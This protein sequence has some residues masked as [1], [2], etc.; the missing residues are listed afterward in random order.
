MLIVVSFFGGL[1]SHAFLGS[2]AWGGLFL[3]AMGVY[4]YGRYKFEKERPL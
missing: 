2:W 4:T 1:A 3:V